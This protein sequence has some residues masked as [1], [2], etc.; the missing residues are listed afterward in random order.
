MTASSAPLCHVSPQKAAVMSL[1][2]LGES[3]RTGACCLSQNPCQS[4]QPRQ[5]PFLPPAPPGHS[6]CYVLSLVPSWVR[7]T[8]LPFGKQQP[9]RHRPSSFTLQIYADPHSVST[10]LCWLE[11]MPVKKGKCQVCGFTFWSFTPCQLALLFLGCHEAEHPGMRAQ[12]S[13]PLWYWVS[14]QLGRS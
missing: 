9:L 5:T 8:C 10:T 14:R 11:H 2:I 1:Q 4:S 6:Q 7:G 12:W 3:Q 13:R